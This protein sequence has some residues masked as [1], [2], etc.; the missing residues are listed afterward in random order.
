MFKAL[1]MKIAARKM[2]RKSTKKRASAAKSRRGASRRNQSFWS[3]VWGAI[4]VP[5]RAIW[6]GIC[7]VWH[8]ICCLDLIGLVNITL[9]C[10]IIVLFSML[11]MDFVGCN[12]KSVVIIKP[13]PEHISNQNHR[14]LHARSVEKVV[15]LP[16]A[17]NE[18]HELIDKPVVTQ[19]PKLDRVPGRQT[20]RVGR[21]M[22]GDVII[23]YRGAV[24]L[25]QPGDTIRGN[26]YLQHMR[27]FVLPRGIV[28][29]GNLFLRDMGMLQF[30]GEFTVTGNIYVTPDSSFGPIPRN[31]RIGG[32][33]IL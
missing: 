11:I 3:R 20:A 13:N 8:W 14:V 27:K 30:A 28:V 23:D 29:D 33:V 15:S 19:E 9:L 32:Q 6:R 7:A 2:N 4:C 31:A 26:L 25:L 5:F 10:A 21:V 22:Y 17:R 24:S 12:K 1:K 18:N 16:M